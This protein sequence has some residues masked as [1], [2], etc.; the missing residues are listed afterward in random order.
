MSSLNLTPSLYLQD[1]DLGHL[2]QDTD[3]DLEPGQGQ[4][5][6]SDQGQDQDIPQDIDLDLDQG[7]DIDQALDPSEI[8]FVFKHVFT[9]VVVVIHD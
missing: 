8:C 4:G 9:S 5:R 1:L 2:F 7:L 6:D 3:L